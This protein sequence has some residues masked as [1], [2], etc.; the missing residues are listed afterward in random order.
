VPVFYAA[1]NE[2]ATL[3]TAFT[4][5]GLLADPDTVTLIVTD[6]LGASTTYTFA[7]GQV[8]H[9]SVGVFWREV[10]TPTAGTWSFQWIG[11]GAFADVDAGTFDVFATDLG[12]LYATPAQIKS[13]L[14]IPAADTAS[15]VELQQA[16]RAASRMVEAYC[17]RIF[18]RG[19]AESRV[20]D[21]H[22]LSEIRFG[23]YNDLVS[24]SGVSTDLDGDGV[25]E[26]AWSASSWQLLPVST[27]GPE[28]RP[29]TALS[30][31][32]SGTASTLLWPYWA[33]PWVRR[34][35]IQITGVFGWPAVP[36]AVGEATRVL[37]AEIFRTKDAPLGLASFG[38]AGLA[39]VRRNPIVDDLLAAY[40]HPDTIGVLA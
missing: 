7:G 20:F 8:T 11:G 40:R 5:N 33:Y 26:S 31:I 23:P 16:C 27:A 22:S 19:L 36:A 9:A 3:S 1:A 12:H 15:D 21:A 10:A 4:L 2:T 13:R 6:P 32:A 17:G 38:E 28:P 24:V 37:A 30:V 29:Y 25:F 34:G 35:R 18:W 39:R 14:S